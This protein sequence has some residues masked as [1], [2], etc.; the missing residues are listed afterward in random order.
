MEI[1]TQKRIFFSFAI[2]CCCGLVVYM[3]IE[4]IAGVIIGVEGFSAMTPEYLA[5]FPELISLKAESLTKYKN[6]YYLRFSEVKPIP[7]D[8]AYS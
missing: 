6:G 8:A 1:K 4:W 3:L 5:L 2:S 7:F